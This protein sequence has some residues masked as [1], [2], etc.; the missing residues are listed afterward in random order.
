MRRINISFAVVMAI[1]ISLFILFLFFPPA[2]EMFA[3]QKSILFLEGKDWFADFFN[4]MRYMSDDAGFYYSK[5]NE[6]DGHSG[7]PIG[8][9][10][11]Y[12]LTQ[13]SNYSE[14]SLQ[15]CWVSKSA[16][17]SC[18]AF[19]TVLVFLLWD[20]LSRLCEKFHVG[21]YNLLIFLFSSTFIFTLE[22][23]NSIFFAAAL[24]NYFLVYYDSSS[25]KLKYFALMC[26]CLA[27]TWKGY[28]V[29]FGLLLLREKRYKDIL[30]CIVF[31]SIIAFVP[32]LFMERGFE[33]FQKMVDNTGYNNASY[34]YSYKYMFGLHKL[35]YIACQCLQL[36][37]SEIEQVIGRTRFVETSL[38]LLTFALVLVEKRFYRQ[39]LLIVCSIL[40]LPINS[41]FYCSLYLF[42]VIVIFF[43]QRECSRMD[44][45]MMLQFCLII[46][47]LQVMVPYPLIQ[48]LTPFVSNVSL[49][50]LWLTLILSTLPA[51]RG[52]LR[53]FSF[54][55]VL[56]T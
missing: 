3:S 41:G 30:F 19:L 1:L 12:P 16:I 13:L 21:K 6:A 45:F 44:Y 26:L 17:F 35:V 32:F 25:V 39:C 2:Q 53:S 14:M 18:V 22:R 5:I 55:T 4:V 8:L 36:M 34:I 15:D 48:N 49:I 40:L 20:S 10:I 56:P 51:L 52:G 50:L 46:N 43:S 37:P 28:P 7:F 38:A 11:M 33:N 29:L 23:A 24:V 27:A 31:T 9:G 54:R 42:P 47:P